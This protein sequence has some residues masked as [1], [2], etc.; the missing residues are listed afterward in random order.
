MFKKL[1]DIIKKIEGNV[2]V[3]SVDQS[4]ISAFNKNNKV[5]LYS[6]DSNKGSK[7]G[8]S[9]KCLLIKVKQ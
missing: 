9:K 7:L 8:S 6:I 3:I 4:L 5:N 1:E 2:L